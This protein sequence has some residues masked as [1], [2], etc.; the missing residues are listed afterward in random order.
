MKNKSAYLRTTLVLALLAI[1]TWL[2]WRPL[3]N[4]LGAR[5]ELIQSADAFLS[6]LWAIGSLT[7]G[8]FW[9][10]SRRSEKSAPNTHANNAGIAIGKTVSHSWLNTGVVLYQIFQTP[11]GK[12]RISEDDF[13]RLLH[14]YFVWAQKAFGQ[15]RLYGLEGWGRSGERKKRN[16]ADVFVPITLQRLSPPARSEVEELAQEK[17]KDD[18]FAE[19][20]AFLRLIET[21][22][23]EGEQITLKEMLTL[24]DRLAIIGGAGSGKST[25]LAFLASSLADHALHQTALPFDLPSHRRAL[26]PLVIPLRYRREYMRLC[27]ESPDQVL[28]KVRSGTLAGFILWYLKKRSQ[29]IQTADE[30]L[31]DEFFDR[32][33]VGGGCLVML[34]GLD[35]VVSQEERGQARQEIERLAN[36]IYPRNLFIVTARESGYKENAIFSEDF[37]RLDVCKL[38]DDQIEY[39][40]R[41]WCEQL[42]PTQVEAQVADITSVI[43]TIN[44]RYE[45][46]N[47]PPLIST[48]LLTTM[49]IGVKWGEA[50]LPR[51][52]A[53]LYEAVVRVILQAQYL[54]E[55]TARQELI[56]WGGA[57]EEQ[58][59][60]LAYL[61]LEMH[62][63]GENGAAV[64]EARLRE[65]LS[66]QLPK[67][68]LDQFIKAVR[69]R[70]GLLEER[71]EL[72]QFTHLTF[73]EFLAARRL[74]KDREQS[75]GLLRD[76]VL[77]SWWREA[78][79]LIYGFAKQDYAPFAQ[80]YLDWLSN[81]RGEGALQLGG[82][83]LA[84]AAV[85]EIERP[86]P[87]I[88]RK[89]AEKLE[90]ALTDPACNA[91]AALRARAG[92]TLAALGD[93]R[94]DEKTFSLPA[95]YRTRPEPTLGFVYI[96]AGPFRM[97][98]AEND[99]QANDDEK[100]PH[101][102]ELPAFYISRYP[103]TNAQFAHFIAEHGYD[104]RRY[105]TPPES[106][107]DWRQEN[108]HS[109]PYDWGDARWGALTR[110]VMG[111]SWYEALAYC[112]WL[113]EK[114]ASL[115]SQY[116]ARDDLSPE[117]RAFW[118][119]AQ[120]PESFSLPSEAQW[121]KAARGVDGRI[122]PWGSNRITPEHANYS[123]TQLGQTS[124]VGIFPK[125]ASPYDVL[126]MSGNVWEWTLSLY[127]PYPYHAEDGR[128]DLQ[129]EG[130]RVMR[131]GS[132]S[133]NPRNARCAFRLWDRPNY[134]GNN[135]GFRVVLSLAEY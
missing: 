23:T 96:P 118:L 122:Y 79:L 71:A 88:R 124:P 115:S 66:V 57:W 104:E 55:D 114:L 12:P 50:E 70:G 83:E 15:A 130:A 119:A 42:F 4:F 99:E 27:H 121:E 82:L 78:L 10:L 17:F 68:R 116:L 91:P 22:R 77:D 29:A 60:W 84:G 112:R 132:W 37:K 45:R 120:R 117:Q 109:Q 52:R 62:R 93:P 61:A 18:P 40:A 54:E 75:L 16:L 95:F 31:A 107:W 48:P 9:F 135:F 14:D 39:L 8:V 5:G 32:L 89:L 98:S 49:V 69:S 33:L 20:K 125:G 74:A 128:N 43:R 35:E 58:R 81:L 59:E 133:Y 53:R 7:S 73:Q 36:E 64:D 103:V 30:D 19:Q 101:T 86:D 113:G 44:E 127:Q 63:N 129:A 134:F 94:F 131:G 87:A 102:L 123:E 106:G 25:L 97:G 56:N 26:V 110:P 92:D 65:I 76:Y 1:V 67:E 85:L 3:M 34:D 100:P 13:R 105:W 51:E 90:A 80:K 38:K 24:G 111:V 46:Q 28:T 11:P 2:G 21:R 126:D 47:Q 6:I 41:R 108:D 72:F